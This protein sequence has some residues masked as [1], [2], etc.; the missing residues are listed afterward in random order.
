MFTRAMLSVAVFM[1][2]SLVCVLWSYFSVMLAYMQ[3][4]YTSG[5]R[6]SEASSPLDGL[7]NVLLNPIIKAFATHP[8]R[9]HFKP[10]NCTKLILQFSG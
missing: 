6:S 3:L 5:I 8:L 1:N 10:K 9:H 2:G 4:L 7:I